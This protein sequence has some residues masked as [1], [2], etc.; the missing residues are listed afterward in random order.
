MHY[1]NENDII[2]LMQKWMPNITIHKHSE[3]SDRIY[4]KIKE[5]YVDLTIQREL[6]N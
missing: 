3:V 6:N 1:K 2:N 4:Q 5:N